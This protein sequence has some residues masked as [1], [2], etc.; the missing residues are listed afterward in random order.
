MTPEEESGWSDTIRDYETMLS[1]PQCWAERQKP[2]FE[3]LP[4]YAHGCW[5]ACVQVLTHPHECGKGNYHADRIAG[6]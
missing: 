4:G 6:N 1:R 5:L 3:G 2:E